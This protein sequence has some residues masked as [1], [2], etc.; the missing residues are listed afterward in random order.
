MTS[1][2]GDKILIRIRS[3][4]TFTQTR[5]TNELFANLTRKI[6]QVTGILLIIYFITQTGRR[7]TCNVT[8][9]KFSTAFMFIRVF[10]SFKPKFRISYSV[11]VAFCYQHYV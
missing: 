5:T 2:A 10:S 7:L 11:M 6:L 4:L 3:S 8:V 9:L 1:D